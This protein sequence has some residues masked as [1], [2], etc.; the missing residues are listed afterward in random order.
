MNDAIPDA[1]DLLVCP[2]CGQ[3]LTAREG[4]LRCGAGHT[5]D[6]ARQGY[7]NLLP[8]D[9]RPGTADSAEMVRARTDFLAAGHYAPL[10]RAVA[11]AVPAA[12]GMVLDAGAGTGYYLAAV[13]AECSGAAGLGLDISKFALRRAARAH[14]RARAAVWDLWRPL[15]VR[16]GAVGALLNVFAPRNP[17]EYR[18]VLAPDGVLVVVTPEPDHLGELRA[19]RDGMLDVEAGKADRLAS[20]LTGSGLFRLTGS[21][22]LTY[23]MDLPPGHAADAIGMGPSARHTEH[24][25][26]AEAFPPV[27]RVTAAFRVSRY[28]PEPAGA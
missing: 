23:A 19:L 25:A 15:P 4:S 6:I 8:G 9:A 26:S 10:A 24:V 21:D 27:V 7:V 1:F 13:L 11:A 18:R 17:A 28:R 22:T 20:G 3:D 12:C 2:L 5:F 14:P 16:T